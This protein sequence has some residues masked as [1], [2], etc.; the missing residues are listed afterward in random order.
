MGSALFDERSKVV[1]NEQ[2]AARRVIFRRHIRIVL[3]GVDL[4]IL[5]QCCSFKLQRVVINRLQAIFDLRR[6]S[7]LQPVTAVSCS[8]GLYFVNACKNVISAQRT[9]FQ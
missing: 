6:N 2:F 3:N 7:G 8:T 9:K 1:D 5:A 4:L